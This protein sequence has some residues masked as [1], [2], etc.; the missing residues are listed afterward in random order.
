M[1]VNKASIHHPSVLEAMERII[2]LQL[3]DH[4]VAIVQI[5]V[6]FI[7]GLDAPNPNPSLSLIRLVHK[8]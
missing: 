2:L 5:Y 1:E 6:A 8:A 4:K 7:A 3:F